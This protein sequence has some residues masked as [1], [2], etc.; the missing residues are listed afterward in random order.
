MCQR[1]ES[2][3]RE[4]AARSPLDIEGAPFTVTVTD[5]RETEPDKVIVIIHGVHGREHH[6]GELH[7]S[8]DTLASDHLADTAIGMME[9]IIRGDLPP[10]ARALL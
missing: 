7:I 1:F 6:T 8:R 9:R 2:L 5:I 3:S 10:G 4:L